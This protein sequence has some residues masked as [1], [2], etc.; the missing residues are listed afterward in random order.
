[1]VTMFGHS[2]A[3]EGNLVFTASHSDTK[4]IQ[5]QEFC[6]HLKPDLVSLTLGKTLDN[7]RDSAVTYDC[8]CHM[9]S[10]SQAP[11][12]VSSLFS[13]DPM[14]FSR[15]RPVKH[16]MPWV[17]LLVNQIGVYS[18]RKTCWIK[19][20][21]ACAG[22]WKNS[23][24]LHL[25][26][27]LDMSPPVTLLNSQDHHTQGF[28]LCTAR[29]CTCR[30][31]ISQS[32]CELAKAALGILGPPAEPRAGTHRLCRLRKTGT[33]LGAAAYKCRRCSLAHVH[34]RHLWDLV[35]HR[36]AILRA[37]SPCHSA[38]S[39]TQLPSLE[40]RAGSLGCIPG[41]PAVTKMLTAVLL[42]SGLWEAS[43]NKTMQSYNHT[44]FFLEH[45]SFFCNPHP[46]ELCFPC[47]LTE[48]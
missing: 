28:R 20:P 33:N 4:R 13:Q 16:Q 25:L 11:C 41:P 43:Q 22:I 34:S 21:R 5:M 10:L 48:T 19:H 32:T 30:S 40:G 38:P 2:Y 27:C 24:I 47:S 8:S 35:S 42:P 29:G 23:V 36:P 18:H 6:G 37:W 44:P 9:T 26:G 3:S 45:K 12:K 14:Q 17:T 15:H 46:W 1:M 39:L 7:K 31:S